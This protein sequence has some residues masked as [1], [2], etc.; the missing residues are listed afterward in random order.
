[1]CLLCCRTKL[2][3]VSQTWLFQFFLSNFDQGSF[4]AV[5][6][7]F[8]GIGEEGCFFMR[9]SGWISKWNSWVWC[10]SI[11]MVWNSARGCPC[12]S[13]ATTFLA[14]EL[15]LLHSMAWAI[16][17]RTKNGLHIPTSLVESPPRRIY[18]TTLFK[19]STLWCFDDSFTTFIYK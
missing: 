7:V 2:E 6:T 9:Q 8:P 4:L 13:L 1:M 11:K 3:G 5:K 17:R 14:D 18:C 16:C 15:A 19:L 10:Q 12:E